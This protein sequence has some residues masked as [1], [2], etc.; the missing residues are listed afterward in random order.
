MSWVKLVNQPFSLTQKYVCVIA[1]WFSFNNHVEA[2]EVDINTPVDAL[3]VFGKYLVDLELL[4]VHLKTEVVAKDLIA[5]FKISK[6]FNEL[7][8]LASFSH[9]LC[10]V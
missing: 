6:V 3:L 8:D 5:N 2:F 1:D 10:Q 7:W 4:F 9:L